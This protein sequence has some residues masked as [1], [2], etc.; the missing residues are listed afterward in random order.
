VFGMVT[1]KGRGVESRGGVLTVFFDRRVVERS[2]Y[3]LLTL[4]V[5]DELRYGLA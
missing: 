3:L 1:T 4:N 5:G 2:Q